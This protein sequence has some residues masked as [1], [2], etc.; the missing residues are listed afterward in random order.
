MSRNRSCFLLFWLLFFSFQQSTNIKGLEGRF[1][2]SLLGR[3]AAAPSIPAVTGTFNLCSCLYHANLCRVCVGLRALARITVQPGGKTPHD[4]ASARR[5]YQALSVDTVTTEAGI[6]ARSKSR[7][8]SG[9]FGRRGGRFGG[10]RCGLTTWTCTKSWNR[11]EKARTDEC[12]KGGGNMS[13][14]CVASWREERI[15]CGLLLSP[16]ARRVC[17]CVRGRRCAVNTTRS[18]RAFLSSS[19]TVPK[20]CLKPYTCVTKCA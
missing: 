20:L 4:G 19:K 10:G 3:R 18:P 8:S 17:A 14:R 7:G 5:R 6:R 11:W 16:A 15:A 1:N 12:S 2:P 9:G 13:A